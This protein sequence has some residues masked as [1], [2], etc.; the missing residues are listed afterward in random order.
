MK[1][2]K[3]KE[4]RSKDFLYPIKRR[5]YILSQG[6]D[7]ED[8]EN[9]S[10]DKLVQFA[11]FQLCDSR[12]TLMEDPIWDRYTD[13]MILLEYYA[14]LYNINKDLREEFE[15]FVHSDVTEDQIDWMDKMIQKNKEELTKFVE[16]DK[17]A[18]D[19]SFEPGKGD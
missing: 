15:N 10:Y 12:K 17:E 11:K 16:A 13:E 18:E 6:S 14:M 1:K 5:A 2:M 9:Y 19:F 4:K 3:T 7:A 8:P